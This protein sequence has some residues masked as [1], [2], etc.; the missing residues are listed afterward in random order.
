MASA[1]TPRPWCPKD[2]WE[3]ARAE[4]AA[5]KPDIM[6]LDEGEQPDLL[7]NAFDVDYSWKLMWT[8]NDVHHS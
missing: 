6:L 5:V 1:A 7:T 8:M 2:F 3:Q 4:L